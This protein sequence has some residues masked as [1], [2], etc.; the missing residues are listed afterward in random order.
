M[1]TMVSPEYIEK[2]TTKTA[3]IQ[4]AIES[5]RAFDVSDDKIKE[6]ECSRWIE[7][8]LIDVIKE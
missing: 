6:Q 7:F 1:M 3:K 4:E 5:L 2:A 8:E